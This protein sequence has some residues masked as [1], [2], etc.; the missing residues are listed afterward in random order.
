MQYLWRFN[1][2]AAIQKKVTKRRKYGTMRWTASE[3]VVLSPHL[4]TDVVTCASEV[5]M[6]DSETAGQESE[7]QAQLSVLG[8]ET[9]RED[10]YRHGA[11]NGIQEST[12]RG[13]E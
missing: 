12:W 13:L 5:E 7:E 9:R 1:G 6:S 2:R 8:A 3:A 11:P 4:V 10:A